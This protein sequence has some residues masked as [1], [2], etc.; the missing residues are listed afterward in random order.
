MYR[1]LVGVIAWFPGP[2]ASPERGVGICKALTVGSGI[3]TG[4]LCEFIVLLADPI[5]RPSCAVVNGVLLHICF[6]L[7]P[8]CAPRVKTSSHSRQ[9]IF[10]SMC[11]SDN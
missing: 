9:T 1:P 2:L 5:A 10:M 7:S 3:G 4:R 11:G 6:A 8:V